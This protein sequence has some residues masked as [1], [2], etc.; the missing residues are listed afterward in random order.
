MDARGWL[1]VPAATHCRGPIC[2]SRIL[3]A[4]AQR[5]RSR[6]GRAEFQKA[7]GGPVYLKALWNT[8]VISGSVTLLC[9]LLGYPIAYA[10]AHA[11]ERLRRLLIF[12]VLIPFWSSI[13]VRTF[14]WMVLLQKKGLINKTLVDYLG[15]IETPLT[16]DLQSHR[17]A[18]RHEPHPA[19]VHDPAALCG[20]GAASSRASARRL[21]ASVRRR[22]RNF[23]RV[24]LPLSLPGLL[25]GS[26]LVFVM[27]L[28]YYITPALARW[29][30]RHHDRAAD[31]DA[32]CGLRQL[33]AGG[34][35]WRSFCCR[36]RQRPSVRQ[37]LACCGGA[38]T[39]CVRIASGPAC[40]LPSAPRSWSF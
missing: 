39:C 17:R 23:L 4:P 5:D 7:G 32:D 1:V 31:R 21:R 35:H 15:L 33:G 28:G 16:L 36:H 38:M 20:A 29:A 24:Y 11:G 12:V 22:C 30:G 40:V 9:V 10:M 14:A 34:A 3:A 8:I 27:G 19:A 26:V 25:A 13:L 2:L 18:D 37:P 6:A